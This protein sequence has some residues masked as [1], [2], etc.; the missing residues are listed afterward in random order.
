[1][2]RTFHPEVGWLEGGVK[3]EICR[4][5]FRDFWLGMGIA[6]HPGL[7]AFHGCNGQIQGIKLYLL[8]HGKGVPLR[9]GV[10]D[11]GGLSLDLQ[12]GEI[13]RFLG[14]DWE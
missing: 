1:V 5:K 2:A 4:L 9:T 12:Q 11:G 13:S 6:Q 14:F 8:A 10:L 3:I 7:L